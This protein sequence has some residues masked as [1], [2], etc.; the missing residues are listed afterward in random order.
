MN[1]P[2]PA[3]L[4][5]RTDVLVVGAGLSGLACARILQEAGREVHV[6][7]ASDG[8][9][10]RV[11]TD[12]MDGFLLDR[13][14]QVLLTAY[15]EVG[16]QVDMD[17]LE[18]QPFK[19]GSLVWTGESLERLGDPWR[20]PGSAVA[21]LKARVGTLGDKMKVAGLRRRLLAMTPEECFTG[22]DRTTREELEAEGF[23]SDFIDT[24]FTPFLGGV[25]LERELSTSARL[26]RYYFRCFSEGDAALP[27]GGMGRLPALLAEPLTGRI[28]LDAPAQAVTGSSV[29]LNG[30]Q[31]LE[32]NRVVLAVDGV[33][34][35]AL[36][37]EEAPAYKGTVTSYFAAPSAPTPHPLLVLDGEGSG[38]VNHVAVLSNVAPGYAP[39]GS[40]LVSV[41]GVGPAAADPESF[42]E[43]V[44]GQLRRWFGDA[45]GRWEHLRTY[46]IDRALPVHPPGSVTGRAEHRVR[47]D[48]LLITGDHTAFGAI[49]GALLAGRR[50]A[51]RV[52]AED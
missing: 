45:V 35:G 19:A 8:I 25:F 14:F 9:G 49:Q 22:E 18:L 16:R 26:F 17:R 20:D 37:G 41:S 1:M 11:R 48:G 4:P 51:E 24:F 31:V 29:T 30:G 23:T 10:G 28:T 21:S 52:L 40:H 32:A 34:A 7:E 33:A 50:A 47:E 36:L 38:P 6:V 13:G 43:G 3:P 27:A 2:N 39:A 44:P 15:R 12:E 46:H 42:R 5:P